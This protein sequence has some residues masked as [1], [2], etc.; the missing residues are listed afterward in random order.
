MS[1]PASGGLAKPDRSVLVLLVSFPFCT[2]MGSAYIFWRWYSRSDGIDGLL[3]SITFV[4]CM[5]AAHLWGYRLYRRQNLPAAKVASPVL[6]AEP[7]ALEYRNANRP[8]EQPISVGA[9]LVQQGLAA[10]VTS[11][12]LDG[13]TLLTLCCVS[14]GVYWLMSGLGAMLRRT[15][16]AADRVLVTIGFWPLLAVIVVL[17]HLVWW[18]KGVL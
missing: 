10:F 17:G 4:C 7:V 1:S 11:I 9:I 6:A 13:G 12:I 2:A 15:P 8:P 14:I 18:A 3:R 5:G 16:T